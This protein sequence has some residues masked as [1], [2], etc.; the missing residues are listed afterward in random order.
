LK[1]NILITGASGFIGS[2]IVEEAIKRNYTTFAGIRKSS[3]KEYL[4][5][6][7]IHFLELNF[8]NENALDQSLQEFTTQYGKFDYIIHSAGLTKAKNKE[9]Y[10]SVNYD[11]TKRFIHA[12]QKN[13]LVPNKFVYISSLASFGPGLGD[14]P[15]TQNQ[16]QQPL[17]AYGDSKRKAEEFLL[18]TPNFPSVIINPT[19]VYGPREKDFYLLLKSIEK[20]FE[21]YIGSKNQL[22]S[23]V[24]VY[25][26]VDA[27]FLAMESSISN[28][29]VLVSDCEVYNPKIV[30]DFIKKI[31]NRKTISFTIPKYPTRALAIITETIG[32]LS[33]SIPILNRERL[34]EFEAMNWSVDCS[35]LKN[36]G[37][38][39][40]YTLENGL[41]QTIQWYQENGLLK[42]NR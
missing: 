26:L 37:Y 7:N 2:F 6:T 14:L 17:T 23:F 4:T 16:P 1:K 27:I 42:K 19:A 8:S 32:K 40:T 38:T 24:H 10:F 35:P 41:Q 36:I 30:N 21:I 9:D 31:M 33:G 3:S 22:L 15:I 39:P 5:N 13:N 12:L 34:K 25:D 11:N 20:H 28:E 18:Q 29:R